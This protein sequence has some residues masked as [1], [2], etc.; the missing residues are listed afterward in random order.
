MKVTPE[1]NSSFKE[2]PS[3]KSLY[4]ASDFHL[5]SPSLEES[6]LREEKIVKWLQYISND[7]AAI[8]LVGDLFD[9]W[10]E[11]GKT[12]PKGF[13]RFQG[14]I[15]E[16]VDRGIPIYFFT[17]N[18]DLWMSDYFKKEIG[19]HVYKQPIVLEVN[20]KRIFV[21][22]GDGLG[23]GDQFYK[24]VKKV[25]TN[26]LAQFFFHWLHPDIGVWMAN[27]WSAK[28]RNSSQKKEDIALGED[29]AL[30]KFC[31]KV[32]ATNH[33]DYYLF[34]HRHLA[35]EMQVSENSTYLNL[36][37]WISQSSYVVFNGQTADI[38]TFN[39]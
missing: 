12:I 21:G 36:G 34:G 17:G 7:A 32:E 9:F 8:F 22:H 27:F 24:V 4:F 28:S 38:K 19:V 29:E 26:R 25:F 1:L 11:Y 5:G 33:H 15:A 6:R 37:E 39:L 10:F 20:E 30:Y 18:H 23:P 14:K 3:N 2:L 13:V 31:K 35:M 16:L